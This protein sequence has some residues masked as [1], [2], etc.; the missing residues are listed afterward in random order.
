MDERAKIRLMFLAT[1][2]VSAFGQNIRL[3]SPINNGVGRLEVYYNGRWGTVCDDSFGA[4]EA[5]VA[6]RQLG[7]YKSG[8]TPRAIQNFGFGRGRIWLDEMK[9]TGAESSLANC[10]H[11]PWGDED[12]AHNEDVGIIC[13]PSD[14][15]MKLT[16]SYKRGLLQV[17]HSGSWGTVC[18]DGFGQVEASVVCRALGYQGGKAIDGESSMKMWLD[19]VQC[20]LLDTDLEDCKHRPWGTHD[21]NSS[22]AVG[23]E[24]FSFPEE[25]TAARIFS[26]TS[27]TGEGILE[28]YYRGRWGRVHYSGFG[29]EEATVACRMLGHNTIAAKA[30]SSPNT[31]SESQ[32]DILEK[33]HCL[34]NEFTLN[35]CLHYPWAAGNSSSI[36]VRIQCHYANQIRLNSTTP[37]Q[38]RVEVLH[39]NVWG[40]V[41][42]WA[43]FFSQEAQVVC[44]MA[45]LPWTNATVTTSYGPGEGLIW[46]SNVNCT[47]SEASLYECSHSV[48]GT[49]PGCS[50]SSDV[51]VICRGDTLRI[52]LEP[53]G[54]VHNVFLGQPISIKCVVDYS[55]SPV[56]SFRWTHS[57]RSYSGQTF[58]KTKVSKS[59]SGTL[60]CNVHNVT[61]STRI[62][63]LL[64]AS[65][66]IGN[67]GSTNYYKLIAIATGTGGLSILIILIIFLIILTYQMRRM[68]TANPTGNPQR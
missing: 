54:S 29:R 40:T 2:T 31:G 30:S 5:K 8:L 51:G 33:V 62:N 7:R 12:C 37:G 60:T 63:V 14:I 68:N 57:G 38:G 67:D 25:A 27:T 20:T 18:D 61:V 56:S 43:S 50:H 41:C 16:P 6:C 34:G 11:R 22:E 23:V 26:T 36:V 59:D 46:L 3:V 39:N 35:E 15:K 58:S 17:F 45:N 13:D 32:R 1:V 42:R 52:K 44:K 24:C 19:D 48:W 47:G 10:S 65:S 21:C 49:T 4:N 9:C 53:P 64:Q 55:N 28:L 66:S